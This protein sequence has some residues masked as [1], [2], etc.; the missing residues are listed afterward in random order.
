MIVGFLLYFFI[1]FRISSCC[2]DTSGSMIPLLVSQI[3]GCNAFCDVQ[4][5]VHDEELGILVDGF[6]CAEG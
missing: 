6:A 3:S 5:D 2:F 4:Q 1:K